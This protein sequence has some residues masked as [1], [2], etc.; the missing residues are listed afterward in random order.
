MSSDSRVMNCN[1]SSERKPF[2][3]HAPKMNTYV[4]TMGSANSTGEVNK[5]CKVIFAAN[6][7]MSF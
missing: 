5:F 7:G 4:D 3:Q 6:D 1:P 2:N